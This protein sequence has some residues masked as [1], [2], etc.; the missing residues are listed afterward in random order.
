[1]QQKVMCLRIIYYGLKI[2]L[3]YSDKLK[4]YKQGSG[5]DALIKIHKN[6]HKKRQKTSGKKALKNS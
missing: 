1:M 4:T 6:M 2:K 5:L 3:Y